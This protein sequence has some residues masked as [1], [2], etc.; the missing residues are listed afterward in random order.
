MYLLIGGERGIRTLGTK[1]M[2][3]GL[4]IHRFKPLGHFSSQEI[5]TRCRSRSL[6][7]NNIRLFILFYF[8]YMFIKNQILFQ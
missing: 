5:I 4:A 7:N 1:K 8:L 2:Y 3:N 6:D